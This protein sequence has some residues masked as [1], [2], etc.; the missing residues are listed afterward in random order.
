VKGEGRERGK[1]VKGEER[2]GQGRGGE[3]GDRARKEG[4]EAC[5]V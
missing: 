5:G 1:G 2:G 3:A 4:V